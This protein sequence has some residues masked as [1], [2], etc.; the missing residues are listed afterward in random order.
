MSS[1]PFHAHARRLQRDT[2]MMCLAVAVLAGLAMLAVAL[3]AG[4]VQ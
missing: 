4:S 2:D 1:N 3:V